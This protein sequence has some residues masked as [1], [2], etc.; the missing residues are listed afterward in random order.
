MR[1]VNPKESKTEEKKDE[2]FLYVLEARPGTLRNSANYLK[3]RGWKIHSTTK[4]KEFLGLIMGSQPP[5]VMICIDHPNPAA[6][7]LPKLVASAFPLTKVIAFVDGASSASLTKLKTSKNEYSVY[8]PLSGPAVERVILRVLKD[9]QKAN[10]TSTVDESGNV[11]QDADR[12]GP[13]A[14]VIK[15]RGTASKMSEQARNMLAQ[16]MSAEE[17]GEIGTGGAYI[18]NPS[19]QSGSRRRSSSV[20]GGRRALSRR[21]QPPIMDFSPSGGWKLR[22]YDGDDFTNENLSS[23]A[24][25]EDSS[26]SSSLAGRGFSGFGYEG[27]GRRTKALPVFTQAEASLIIKATDTALDAS[28]IK[29]K[30]TPTTERIQSTTSVAC[31]AVDSVKFTGYLVAALG[32]NRKIDDR[33]INSVRSRLVEYMRAAGEEFAAEDTLDLN[34]HQVEFEAWALKQAE[35]LRKT[36]HDGQEIAMAFFP[37]KINNA[38][39]EIS[40]SKNM[41]KLDID[42]LLGNATMEFDLYVHLPTNNKYVLY[43]RQDQKLHADQLDRLKTKG[44]QSMH[45]RKEDETN[46]RRY[47]VRNFLNDKIK[48]HEDEVAAT[49][50]EI[51]NSSAA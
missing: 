37:E 42:E 30:P 43:T 29:G 40:A 27:G 46:V 51:K 50:A 12:S 19:V 21:A 4:V 47:R 25:A 9:L 45:L 24:S 15:G 41:L 38:P 1:H 49:V 8:P 14:V 48:E 22:E 6:A 17:P 32:N 28:V 39:L 2:Q 5:F 7:N 33:F 18:P 11:V 13:D 16:F 31:I 35:F 10:E 26:A 20:F 44:V 34:L 36:I 3:N 23:G